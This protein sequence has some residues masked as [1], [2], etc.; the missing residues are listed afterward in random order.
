[1]SCPGVQCA[2]QQAITA[3]P[4]GR[5][6]SD[7]YPPPPTLCRPEFQPPQSEGAGRGLVPVWGPTNRAAYLLPS[8][9]PNRSGTEWVTD[10]TQ[11]PP[12]APRHVLCTLAAGWHILSEA[13]PPKLVRYSN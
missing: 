3:R 11:P 5:A 7:G 4:M 13:P 10:P 1:M 8:P 9:P 2:C 12:P 6:G